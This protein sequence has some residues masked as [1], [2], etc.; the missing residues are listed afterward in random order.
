MLLACI[1]SLSVIWGV[2]RANR[3]Q[4]AISLMVFSLVTGIRVHP[5]SE[6]ISP[7][8]DKVL[9]ERIVQIDRANPGIWISNDWIL[10]ALPMMLGVES[11]AGTQQYCNY[12]FWSNVDNQGIYKSEWNRYAHLIITDLEDR[13]VPSAK[14]RL[15]II[16]YSL[17]ED[18]IRRLGIRYVLWR[19]RPQNYRWLRNLCQVG[20]VIIY[21]VCNNSD[22]AAEE[23]EIVVRQK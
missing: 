20:D 17:G 18:K 13:S 14:D 19:G 2:L 22:E 15:D 8:Y 7:V 11:W 16:R 21:E 5:L 4:F 23:H 3:R 10:G 9:S 1:V 6:G 12:A